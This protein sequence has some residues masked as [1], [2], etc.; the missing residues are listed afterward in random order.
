MCV[1]SGIT[2]RA[3]LYL[4]VCVCVCVCVFREHLEALLEDKSF[5]NELVLFSVDEE[6]TVVQADHRDGLMP[7]LMRSGLHSTGIQ[8]ESCDALSQP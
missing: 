7:V 3:V 8:D 6:C 5:K 1:C 2:W 4:Y